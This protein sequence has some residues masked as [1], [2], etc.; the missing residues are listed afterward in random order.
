MSLSCILTSSWFFISLFYSGRGTFVGCKRGEKNERK[1]LIGKV[2]G[3]Y[4]AATRN[5]QPEL[6]WK[7]HFFKHLLKLSNNDWSTSYTK[8][9]LPCPSVRLPFPVHSEF[10]GTWKFP[11][12][13][14]LVPT[15]VRCD[16]KAGYLDRKWAL[17]GTTDSGWLSL[18]FQVEL[19]QSPLALCEVIGWLIAV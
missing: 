13:C 10:N 9:Q 5:F 3:D 16:D 7:E 4:S 18:H 8:C 15:K 19:D 1:R 14:S 2:E 6:R 12:L 17:H 11:F